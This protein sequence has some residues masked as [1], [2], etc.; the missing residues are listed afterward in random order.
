MVVW[1]GIQIDG[2]V[3]LLLYV[4]FVDF[5]LLQLYFFRRIDPSLQDI[6]LIFLSLLRR[7]FHTE[8]MSLKVHSPVNLPLTDLLEICQHR[9]DVCLFGKDFFKSS[10]LR[11]Q[12]L[13]IK[14]LRHYVLGL[15][16]FLD[17]NLSGCLHHSQ[18]GLKL[19]FEFLEG[20]FLVVNLVIVSVELVFPFHRD[21]VVGQLE[22]FKGAKENHGD[23]I[24]IVLI[25]K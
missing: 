1:S 22:G 13:L 9:V 3:P 21:I 17:K 7:V 24:G 25:L 11:F 12:S 14:R 8:V 23:V 10:Y 5:F 20:F 2:Q 6:F 16:V 4:Q 15:R 18:M 19:A